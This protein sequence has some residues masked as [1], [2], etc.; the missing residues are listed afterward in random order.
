MPPA[1]PR[2]IRYSDLGGMEGVL[3]DIRELV[4]YPLCHPEV[5]RTPEPLYLCVLPCTSFA[6]STEMVY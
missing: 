2:R 6:G 4:E 3:A 5:P 1:G